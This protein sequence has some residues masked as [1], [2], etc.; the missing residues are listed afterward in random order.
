MNINII[1]EREWQPI[2]CDLQEQAKLGKLGLDLHKLTSR[3]DSEMEKWDDPENEIVRHGHILSS[4]A[5][6]MYLFTR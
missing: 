1:S 3:V 4:T 6:S 2:L 5:Y